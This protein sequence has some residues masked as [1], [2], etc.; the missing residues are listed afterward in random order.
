MSTDF[1]PVY[2]QPFGRLRKFGNIV[3]N[4]PSSPVTLNQDWITTPIELVD[5]TYPIDPYGY[6]SAPMAITKAA[7]DY[8]LLLNYGQNP[9]LNVNNT[10]GLSYETSDPSDFNLETR[11]FGNGSNPPGSG[12]IK[13]GPSAFAAIEYQWN[14]LYTGLRQFNN[15]SG[16][17]EVGNYLLAVDG[18]NDILLNNALD[19]VDAPFRSMFTRARIN[20]LELKLAK[21]KNTNSYTTKMEFILLSDWIAPTPPTGDP[22]ATIASK[23]LGTKRKD[24]HVPFGSVIS[25]AGFPFTPQQPNMDTFTLCNVLD[26][27]NL[28][29]DV[30][31]STVPHSVWPLDHLGVNPAP[32]KP[33]EATWE[34]SFISNNSWFRNNNGTILYTDQCYREIATMYNNFLG[35]LRFNN[36]GT[37]VVADAN[38]S[39]GLCKARI[40]NYPLVPTLVSSNYLSTKVTFEL[41]SDWVYTNPIAVYR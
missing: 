29:W 4:S 30:Q 10:W 5:S 9:L 19:D 3:F 16:I 37:L 1:D 23:N 13:M 15:Q 6:D 36:K 7:W 41:Y 39:V 12:F 34:L 31:L 33:I 25:F 40:K 22:N 38:G 35:F 21:A 18:Q 2:A 32:M 28:E 8:N 20:T 14:M 24:I 17:L 27:Y 11:Y 26:S